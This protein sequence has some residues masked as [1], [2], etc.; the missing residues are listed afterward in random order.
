MKKILAIILSGLLLILGNAYAESND[1]HNINQQNLSRQPYKQMP[2]EDQVKD[3]GFEGA[4]LITESVETDKKSRQ[5]LLHRFDRRPYM[6]KS[7]S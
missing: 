6:E 4:T 3:E 1:K 5:I 2:A 7:A